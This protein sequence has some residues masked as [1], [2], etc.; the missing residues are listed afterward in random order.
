VIRLE[1]SNMMSTDAFQAHQKEM[2]Q[3]STF[4]D[5]EC[6]LKKGQ[7]FNKSRANEEDLMESGHFMEEEEFGLLIMYL[8]KRIQEVVKVEQK[9]MDQ[10]FE[11]QDLCYSTMALLDGGLRR[12]VMCRLHDCE[13]WRVLSEETN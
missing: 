4:L 1:Q 12:E 13:E 2:I 6:S 11:L 3:A 10:L 9:S 5:L 8:L 7:D